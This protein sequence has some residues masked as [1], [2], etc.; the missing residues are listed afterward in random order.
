MTEQQKIQYLANV[1]CAALA[2]GNAERIEDKV[3]DGIAK[4]IAA[5][6]FETI[7]AKQ[8]GGQADFA[9]QPPQRLSDRIRNVEDMLLMAYADK[10]LAGPEKT[11]LIE[12]ANRLGITKDQLAVI[13]QETKARLQ[14]IKKI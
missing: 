8:L 12:Y 2:D 14:E 6:Y 9:V 10:K 11:L 4:G 5:G 3:L 1:W 13:Q 7:K